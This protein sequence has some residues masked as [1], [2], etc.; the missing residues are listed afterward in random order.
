LKRSI[1]VARVAFTVAVIVVLAGWSAY[2]FHFQQIFVKRW[3][4]VMTIKVP[5]AQR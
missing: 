3:G 4:G 1:A 5:E 2:Y